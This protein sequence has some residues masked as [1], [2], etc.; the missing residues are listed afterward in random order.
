[1]WGREKALKVRIIYG[2]AVDAVSAPKFVENRGIQGLLVGRASV[3]AKEFVSI[4]KA[5]SK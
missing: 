1:L 3:D 2:G 4:I 5:F